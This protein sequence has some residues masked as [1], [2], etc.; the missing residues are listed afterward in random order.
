VALSATAVALGAAA[1]FALSGLHGG[2]SG[3]HASTT[4]LLAVS[5]SGSDSNPCSTSAPCATFDHAYHVAQPGQTVQV[6]GGTYPT[7][8]ITSDPTKVT[9]STDVTFESAPGQLAIVSG[10]NI[11]QAAHIT[12][13]G[14]SVAT[15]QNLAGAT[16]G[17]TLMPTPS[18]VNSGAFSGVGQCSTNIT[19]RGIDQRML[20]VNNS[21]NISVYGG[22]IGGH[23]NTSGDTTVT[24]EYYTANQQVCPDANPTGILFHG[25]LFHDV[26]R[27]LAPT[28]HPDCLQFSG[29]AGTTVED[30]TFIRCGTSNILARPALD[31]WTGAQ[32]TGL[33]IRNNF[34]API[35]ESTGNQILLGGA[36]DRCGTVDLEYNTSAAGLATFTC[37]SYQSL[38][39]VGN[40]QVSLQR[41]GCQFV[42]SKATVYDFNAI[43]AAPGPTDV[44]SCGTNSVLAGD[45]QFVDP[46]AFDYRLEPTS[47]LIGRGGMTHPADDIDGKKRPTTLPADIGAS[48]WDSA[49]LVLGKSIGMATLGTTESSI[50]SAYGQPTSTRRERGLRVATYRLHDGYLVVRYAGA[51]VVGLSTTTPYYTTTA[52]FGVG[53]L[54]PSTL[55]R[56]LACRR[57]Y[58]RTAGKTTI[59]MTLK[60]SGTT[61]TVTAIGMQQAAYKLC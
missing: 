15:A 35:I 19:F 39:V 43:G 10:L 24:P 42:L 34:F 38:T 16:S 23:N 45:P 55:G 4:G 56:L 31:I 33:V 30:S 51:A 48:Q 57:S 12:F 27:D 49:L 2:H 25:V 52:G 6:A 9:A 13:V 8:T 50:T 54:A 59:F 1:V 61:G 21:N 5:T 41:F 47:P 20:I 26:T 53:S 7:E 28:A 17:I 40:Y 22:A 58:A 46:G 14:N 36:P 44:T 32:I 37:S 29:T 3:V 18:V 60:G 11:V